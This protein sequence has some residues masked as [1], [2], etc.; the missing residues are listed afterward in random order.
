MRTL[1]V[2]L[3]MMFWSTAL[4]AQNNDSLQLRFNHMAL[5]VKDVERSAAFYGGVLQLSE[6]TNRSK[7]DG[8]RWFSMGEGKELHLISIV[9]EPVQ[10]NKAIHLALT[11]T[12]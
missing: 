10:V 3:L 1:I 12:N 8:V 6:I 9:K 5:S 2:G 11:T 7:L 4:F